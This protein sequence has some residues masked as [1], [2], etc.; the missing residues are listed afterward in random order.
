MFPLLFWFSVVLKEEKPHS[1]PGSIA[2]SLPLPSLPPFNSAPDKQTRVETEWGVSPT[3]IVSPR[4]SV[5]LWWQ[6]AGPDCD[7]CSDTLWL[8]KLEKRRPS[9]VVYTQAPL[10]T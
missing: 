6:L 10:L 8:P 7:R 2:P 1:Q 5:T 4:Q 3:L 9:G